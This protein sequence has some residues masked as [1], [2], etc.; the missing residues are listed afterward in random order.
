MSRVPKA[1]DLYDVDL[2]LEK[3][4]GRGGF[5]LQNA[6]PVS[7]EDLLKKHF[8]PEKVLNGLGSLL[9]EPADTLQSLRGVA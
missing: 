8:T 7:M 9:A 5:A 4:G 6:L 2:I 1:D 3:P